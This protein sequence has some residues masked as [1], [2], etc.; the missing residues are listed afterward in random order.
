MWSM[1]VYLIHNMFVSQTTSL[2]TFQKSSMLYMFTP[3]NPV[4]FTSVVRIHH[5]AGYWA[6]STMSGVGV[7]C[8]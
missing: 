3:Q 8:E 4:N 6:V 1:L 5:P 7:P 2:S